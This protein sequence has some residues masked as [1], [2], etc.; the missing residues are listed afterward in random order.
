MN[1]VF[2]AFMDFKWYDFT[3]KKNVQPLII[4]EPNKWIFDHQRFRVKIFNDNE[5]F[6]NIQTLKRKIQNELW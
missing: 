6:H 1:Y 2:L 4:F 5:I 3:S